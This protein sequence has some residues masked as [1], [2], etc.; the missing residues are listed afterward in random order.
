MIDGDQKGQHQKLKDTLAKAR[1]SATTNTLDAMRFLNEASESYPNAVSLAAGRPPDHLLS[2]ELCHYWLDKYVSLRG[3]DAAAGWATIGQYGNTSGV[4]TDLVAKH[5]RTQEGVEVDAAD[6]VVTNGFQEAVLIE[7][8]NLRRAGGGVIAMEPTYVGLA[9]AAEAAGVP[10]FT[11]P[12]TE[13]PGAMLA[14]TAAR[15]RSTGLDR[16]AFYVIPDFA[17]PT[18]VCLTVEARKE[19]LDVADRH[20][21]TIWEDAA[22]RIF[23]Y[24]SEEIPTLLSLDDIGNVVHLGTFSKTFLPGVRVGFSVTRRTGA[25]WRTRTEV[26]ST[27]SFVSVNTSPI[28]QAIVGGFLADVD[29][30]LRDWN[31]PRVTFCKENRDVLLKALA[32]E[33]RDVSGVVWSRPEG[34]FFVVVSLPFDFDERDLECAARDYGVIV[35]PMTFFSPTGGYRSMVRLSFSNTPPEQIPI[36]VNR[37]ARYVRDQCAR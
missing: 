9:G 8:L 37:L 27:K 24:H 31:A 34:G 6:C 16:L 3:D 26:V 36:A 1:R 7:L 2:T 19:L 11:F 18:G 33:F 13:A 35:V 20:R 14:A 4:I 29:F 25:T 32:S 10:L 22:Y 23:R 5:L 28:S 30:N 17:N 21:I 15:A 12:A